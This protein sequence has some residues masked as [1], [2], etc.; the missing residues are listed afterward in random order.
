MFCGERAHA[1]AVRC[2]GTV[3][4]FVLLNAFTEDPAQLAGGETQPG[5][6]NSLG[7]GGTLVVYS[8]MSRKPVTASG[9]DIVFR[10]ITVRGF[11]L[12]APQTRGSPKIVD[13]LKLGARPSWKA[14]PCTRGCTCTPTTARL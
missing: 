9:I 11:W 13:A 4:D 3:H 5:R 8:F 6:A 12:Y 7:P 2:L 10:D 14:S 1:Q